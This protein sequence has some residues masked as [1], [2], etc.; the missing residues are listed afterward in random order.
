MVYETRVCIRLRVL[1]K[2]TTACASRPTEPLVQA[3]SRKGWAQPRGF[4]QD[5]VET[6]AG[7]RQDLGRTSTARRRPGKGC[8]LVRMYN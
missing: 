1:S 8:V 3:E 7:P 5:L 2:Q 4:F 6:S